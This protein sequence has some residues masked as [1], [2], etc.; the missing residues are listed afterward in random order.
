MK[1]YLLIGF[2][3]AGLPLYSQ[4]HIGAFAGTTGYAGDLNGSFGKRLK[5]ALGASIVYDATRHI[6]LRGGVLLGKLEGGDKYGNSSFLKEVRNLSFETSLTEFHTGLSLN[7]FDLNRKNWTPYAFGALA[8]FHFDPYVRDSGKKVFLKPLST[9]GQG[10]PNY[11][12]RETYSLLQFSLPFGGG[13]KFV[14]NDNIILGF[15]HSWR[16]TFT[17]YIDDVSTTYVDAEV[18]L[19]AKGDVANRFAYRGD[20]VPGGDIFYPDTGNPA[21]GIQRGN[22]KVKDWYYYTGIHITFRI[23]DRLGKRYNRPKKSSGCATL[24]VPK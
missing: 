11:P 15:E 3:L 2:L 5:P 24:F 10:L 8:V 7:L 21:E 19:A 14:L 20:E 4:L 16:K 22:N 18:L 12:D 1:N 9:E 13:L 17:D 6:S 23:A